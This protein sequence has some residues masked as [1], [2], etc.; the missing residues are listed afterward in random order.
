[1]KPYLVIF[2]SA[3]LDPKYWVPK[4][5]INIPNILESNFYATKEQV[6]CGIV[7]EYGNGNRFQFTFKERFDKK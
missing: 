2:T 7:S 5:R 3:T 6:L 1:M 4:L